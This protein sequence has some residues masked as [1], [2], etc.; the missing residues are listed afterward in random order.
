M[1]LEAIDVSWFNGT[2]SWS[3]VTQSLAII[4]ATNGLD[5]TVPG[6]NASVDVNYATN[7][8][9]ARAAG[10]TV[11][12]YHVVDVTKSITQQVTLFLGVA[13]G[14]GLLC[15]DVEH[16]VQSVSTP[17]AVVAW[18]NA[19]IA[20]I[21]GTVHR[22]VIVYM[23]LSTF[24]WC[25]SPSEWNLWLGDAG[26]SVPGAPCV[27]WQY[28]QGLVAGIGTTTDFDRWMEST[29]E[30]KTMTGEYTVQMN[31][32]PVAILSSPTGQGY[33]IVCSDG[34]V[35]SFGDFVFY[36]SAGGIKLN[37]PIVAAAMT[38]TGKGYWLVGSDGGVFAYGDAGFYGSA[39]A[40][41][42]NAPIVA[43][44]VTATGKGYRLV[45][46]DGGVFDYGDAIYF[47]G[48]V[49]A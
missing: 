24:E 30:L 45:A 40:E 35:F 21:E 31:K 23:D 49:V 17:T 22:P 19:A 46:A 12:S 36:G 13:R 2:I 44:A 42:L 11:G 37:A 38:V 16:S 9:G 7:I 8:A 27:I 20:L 14:P 10:K 6:L 39:G 34:G 43:V 29:A 47:G 4:R 15:L 18:V 33:G 25:G 28:S 3:R 48:G 32:P 41:R 1:T 26:V 5:V